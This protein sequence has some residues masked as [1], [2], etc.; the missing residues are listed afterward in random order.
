MCVCGGGGLTVMC[1]SVRLPVLHRVPALK[2]GCGVMVHT[3]LENFQ[4][5]DKP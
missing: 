5:V 4:S 2:V 1:L 3:L